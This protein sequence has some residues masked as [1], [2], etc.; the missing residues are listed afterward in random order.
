MHC[1]KVYKTG[2]RYLN[3]VARSMQYV[4]HQTFKKA[5]RS[6]TV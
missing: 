3:G 2:I 1:V 6:C 4:M 5:D